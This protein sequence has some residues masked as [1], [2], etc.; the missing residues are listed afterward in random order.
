MLSVMGEMRQG[1]L[2]EA[3][4]PNLFCVAVR[5]KVSFSPLMHLCKYYDKTIKVFAQCVL[6]R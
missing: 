3:Y 1:I 6:P 4:Y 5:A 2:Q